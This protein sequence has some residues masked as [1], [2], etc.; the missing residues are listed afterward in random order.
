[1]HP[2][3]VEL[4]T[5]A[6]P[7]TASCAAT[8]GLLTRLACRVSSHAVSLERAMSSMLPMGAQPQQRPGPYE[9]EPHLYFLTSSATLVFT[10]G[11][12]MGQMP[13]ATRPTPT[14]ADPILCTCTAELLTHLLVSRAALEQSVLLQILLGAGGSPSVRCQTSYRVRPGGRKLSPAA[15]LC[16]IHC[17]AASSEGLNDSPQHRRWR[18]ESPRWPS[19]W[20]A[21]LRALLPKAPPETALALPQ[22]PA[23]PVQLHAHKH[24]HNYH[25]SHP[26]AA[27][28]SAAEVR[29]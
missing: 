21:A 16:L 1:M 26:M 22:H 25:V 20:C 2:G 24:C 13:A 27:M 12:C 5:P 14:P 9:A 7:D 11:P 23:S 10:T 3:C 18:S 17:T 8:H 29:V 6:K 4:T 19:V 28:L 15:L